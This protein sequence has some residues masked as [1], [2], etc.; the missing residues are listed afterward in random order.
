MKGSF[1]IGGRVS[2][3]SGAY[4]LAADD[5]PRKRYVPPPEARAD[6]DEN[7]REPDSFWIRLMTWDPFPVIMF[8]VVVLWVGLGLSARKWPPM[9]LVLAGVGLLVCLLGELYLYALIFRDGT[10]HGLLSFFFDWYRLIYLHMNIEL[11]LKPTIISLSGLFMILTGVF[12][13]LN[14]I[15]PPGG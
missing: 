15:K 1:N 10:E 3:E 7:E 6:K 9:G 13:F 4:S 14:N 11:T 5:K 2:D 12:V 8:V